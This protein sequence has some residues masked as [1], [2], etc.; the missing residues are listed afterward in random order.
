MNPQP[1]VA[2]IGGG[3]SG[4][5]CALTL[6]ERGI[7]STIFDTGKHGLGG[8]M[9]TRHL[10][11]EGDKELV[12][13]HAAQF[14]TSVDSRFQRLVD[15]WQSEGLVK[16]WEGVVGTIRADG[17][18]EELPEERR[19]IGV[20]GMRT[21]CDKLVEKNPLITVRRPVW[22]SH[23]HPLPQKWGLRENTERQGDFDAVVIAHNGKCANRLLAPAGVPKVAKQ[24]KKLELSAIWALMA[25]FDRPLPPPLG[26]LSP[27]ERENSMG[28]A[29]VEGVPS[30]SFM[31]NNS[32]KLGTKKD[33]LE[34][35]TF[36]SSGQYGKRNK[37][38]QEAI[39]LARAQRVAEEMLGGVASALGVTAGDLP[40]PV[41]Q[42]V[43][44]WGAALPLNAP[45][46]ECIFDSKG[47]VGICGDWLLSPSVEGAAVSG[48]AL[49]NHIAEFRD[50][51][52]E[53]EEFS[54]GLDTQFQPTE[55]HD[56]GFFPSSSPPSSPSSSP[57]SPPTSPSANDK[58]ETVLAHQV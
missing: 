36:F 37:V 16:E 15:T 23:L 53:S 55:G 10:S 45:G 6:A 29:F 24:M 28:G 44:L 34:C 20:G 49:A 25:A 42:K 38:P 2:I 17:K 12:F 35:W 33:G 56:I 11:L 52:G 1:H 14:F 22:I 43:Q 5:V 9:A 26:F 4:I 48:M 3:I 21:L 39:P 41:Y 13:D 8:R 47:R 18:F 46:V 7:Q 40:L 54:V 57:T 27:P 19:Y 50:S 51:G 30:L 31:S 32:S 58:Q